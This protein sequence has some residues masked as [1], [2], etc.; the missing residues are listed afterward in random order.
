MENRSQNGRQLGIYPTG[1]F[2]KSDTLCSIRVTGARPMPRG[3]VM[4]DFG[5][6]QTG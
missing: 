1:F 2:A 5:W 3:T 6:S 4:R